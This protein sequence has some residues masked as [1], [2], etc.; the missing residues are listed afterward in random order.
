[1]D[2]EYP[3]LDIGRFRFPVYYDVYPSF[4]HAASLTSPML[5][6][7]VECQLIQAAAACWLLN[8]RVTKV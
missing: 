6:N 1:V 5:L 4:F 8:A 7:I 3:R 2:Q